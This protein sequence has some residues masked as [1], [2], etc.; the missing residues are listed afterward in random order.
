MNKTI[1][2]CLLVTTFIISI[3]P[4]NKEILYGSEI[5][6]FVEIFEET[7][8]LDIRDYQHNGIYRYNIET[9]SNIHLL[10]YGSITNII[11]ASNELLYLVNQRGCFY[12]GVGYTGNGRNGRHIN[13]I[14][15]ALKYT[16]SSYLVQGSIRY[17]AENL[18]TVRSDLPWVEGTP[19][20]GIG[21]YI[22]MEWEYDINGLIII[23]G[24]ISL[25]RPELYLYNNRVKLI[26]VSINDSMEH[27]EYELADISSP[28]IIQLPRQGTK[29]KVEIA[30]VYKG[31]RWDDTCVS[32]IQGISS[33]WSS[34]FFE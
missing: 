19:G 27:F 15:P 18:R 12:E 16:S 20:N 34:A 10:R 24:F 4:Q 28:Q 25:N 32:M 14:G 26:R 3:Y 2:F 21:E 11:C 5:D 7:I 8:D 13:A 23:N 17:E 29:I 22:E 9:R 33:D 31:S 1:L 6:G 30:D